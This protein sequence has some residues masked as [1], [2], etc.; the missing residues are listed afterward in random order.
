MPL[1]VHTSGERVRT[2]PGSAEDDRLTAHPAWH[3]DGA[4]AVAPHRP[5][6]VEPDPLD[7]DT[8]DGPDGAPTDQE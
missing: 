7:G 3:L 1:H 2:V 8:A 6:N 5:D 4:P